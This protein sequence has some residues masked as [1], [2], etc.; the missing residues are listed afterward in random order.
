MGDGD[1]LT[2]RVALKATEVP[3][4]SLAVLSVALVGVLSLGL[5]L[6]FCL[7]LI[8]RHPTDAERYIRLSGRSFPLALRKADQSS[9]DQ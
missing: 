4:V 8:E 7:Y 9:A 2:R 6:G 1:A 5:W 3:I